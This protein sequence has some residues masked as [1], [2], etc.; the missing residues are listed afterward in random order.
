MGY[1]GSLDTNVILRLL[2]DDVP[3]QNAAVVE[4]IDGQSE[5]QLAVA[6]VALVEVVFVLER[7]YGIGRAEISGMIEGVMSLVQ[8]NCN[9]TLLAKALPLFVQ[10]PSLSFEDCCLAV[11]A[12][13]NDA[14]PLWTFDKDLAKRVDSASLLASV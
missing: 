9:R 3:E 1:S 4:L 11:Y 5:N 13:L 7:Y 8:I 2:L 6:D 14:T 10:N 12:E